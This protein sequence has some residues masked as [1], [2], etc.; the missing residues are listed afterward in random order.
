MTQTSEFKEV[1]SRLAYLSDPQYPQTITERAPYYFVR[2]EQQQAPE[3]GKYQTVLDLFPT[4][5][6]QLDELYTYVPTLRRSL[7][8][9]QAADA[10]RSLVATT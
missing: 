6:S 3:Q 7:R 4:D 1:D 2:F 10:H 8:L 9:S 5:P